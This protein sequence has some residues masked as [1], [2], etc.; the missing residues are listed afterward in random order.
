MLKNERSKFTFTMKIKELHFV[1]QTRNDFIYSFEDGLV[2]KTLEIESEV[3][4]FSSIK[5]FPK[6][7]S[8]GF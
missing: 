5:Y 3:L 6:Y 1:L 4:F 7:S 8:G 2:Q